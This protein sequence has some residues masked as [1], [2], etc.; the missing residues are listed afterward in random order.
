MKRRA[1][2]HF[3]RDRQIIYTWRF[4]K[5]W[6]QHYKTLGYYY[7]SSVMFFYLRFLDP[8]G[9]EKP[10]GFAQY[11]IQPSGNP[12]SNPW[13][14]QEPVLAAAVKFMEL[15]QEAVWPNDWQ[16]RKNF[17]F[18][19]DKKPEDFD[20]QLALILQKIDEEKAAEA[21]SQKT[22]TNGLTA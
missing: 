12:Y 9:E 22:T 17:Y 7:N 10:L 8:D 4:G 21:L 19:D 2:I 6:A 20:R 15:G 16:G 3:D 5:V 13:S 1:P 11:Q 14:E 18:F